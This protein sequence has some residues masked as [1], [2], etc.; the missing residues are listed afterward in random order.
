MTDLAPLQE[1]RDI[2]VVPVSD[3]AGHIALGGP[4]WPAFDRQIAARHC[5]DRQPVDICPPRPAEARPL[6]NPA[7]WGGFLDLKFGHLIVKQMTRLPQSLRNRPDDLYLLTLP[8]GQSVAGLPAWVW[9]ILGWHGVP[10]RRVR[11]VNKALGVAEL[12]VAAQG[13]MM[14]KQPTGAAYLD[15]LD[16]NMVRRALSPEPAPVVFVTRAGMVARGLGG[17]AGAAYLAQVLA[18]AGVR[19][20]DPLAQGVAGQMAIYAGAGVLVFSEGSALH[21]RLLL[22]RVAQDIHV[23]RCRP[24]RDIGA[25]QLAP[26]CRELRYH[27]AAGQRLGA[28]MRA[29][30]DRYDLMA[31]L[32]DLEVVFEVFGGLGHDLRPHC[33]GAAQHA[34]VLHDLRGWLESCQTAPDQVL[35]NL[36]L[37]AQAGFALDHSRQPAALP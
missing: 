26:R 15:L 35:D 27:A 17:H 9:Q 5:R 1:F 3:V 31:A 14:G 18:R 12:R 11:L 19:V 10:R 29:G 4:I 37:L 25:E 8:P 13:E 28:R 20:V 30:G 36:N 34:A 16:A 7:V 33:D 2:A 6:R 22:G 21:G 23:L 24:N 32:Y